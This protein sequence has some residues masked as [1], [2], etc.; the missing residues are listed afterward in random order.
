MTYLG[1]GAAPSRCRSKVAYLRFC[2]EASIFPKHD[3]CWFHVWSAELAVVVA[4]YLHAWTVQNIMRD[5][6]FPQSAVPRVF[7]VPR[8]ISS[9]AHVDNFNHS[10]QDFVCDEHSDS[11]F[12]AAL[13]RSSMT[14]L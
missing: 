5:F 2:S 10:V 13:E 7:D 1:A 9:K 4:T 12:S 14:S 6:C 8:N 11:I 3:R